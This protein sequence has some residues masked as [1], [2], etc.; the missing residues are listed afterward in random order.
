MQDEFDFGTD[1]ELGNQSDSQYENLVLDLEGTSDELPKFEPI[2]PG[3]YDAIVEN[4]EFGPSQ[5]S[6]NPMLTWQF[7]ITQSPYE[8]RTL[9]FWTVLNKEFGIRMLKRILTRIAPDISL[10]NFSP[11]AFAESGAV[12]GLP[13]RLKITT[14]TYQGER[15]N[16]I[17]DIL[18]PQ[19]ADSF[20]D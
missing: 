11:K 14:R 13:C 15:R 12:L 3:V 20:F 7:R 16:N 1:I 19:S 10:S 8:N 18:P 2:P 6:G 17:K 9:F 5:N 4:V